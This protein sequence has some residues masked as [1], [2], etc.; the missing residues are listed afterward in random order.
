M[1]HSLY[2]RAI[3]TFMQAIRQIDRRY[4]DKI[5]FTGVDGDDLEL[6][7]LEGT[8]LGGVDYILAAEEEK[9]DGDC[10][11]LKDVSSSTDSES[12]YEIVE[13][14]KELDYLIGVFAELLDDTDIKL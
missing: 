10:Y 6:F 7:V 2:C 5:T 13:D 11:I 1:P 8:R 4:M 14:E 9:G 3:W 12:V